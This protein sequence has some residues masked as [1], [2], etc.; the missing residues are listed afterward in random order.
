MVK[1]TNFDTTFLSHIK[2]FFINKKMVAETTIPSYLRVSGAPT[3]KKNL[4][5]I[6]LFLLSK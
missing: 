2:S 4:S 5:T 1:I 6:Y 3:G